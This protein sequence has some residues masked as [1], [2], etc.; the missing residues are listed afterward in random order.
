MRTSDHQPTYSHLGTLS[1]GP[2]RIEMHLLT[3]KLPSI[4]LA[5]L[6]TAV[7][8]QKR[9]LSSEDISFL[10]L[11]QHLGYIES[12][13]FSTTCDTFS[14]NDPSAT[15]FPAGLQAALCLIAEQK[16]N[17]VG[18]IG[19]TLQSNGAESIPPCTYVAPSTD[20]IDVVYTALGLTYIGLGAYIG[21]S[22][23]SS[24]PCLCI[25]IKLTHVPAF[26]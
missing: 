19:S 5:S 2:I 15:G 24:L 11:V 10:H 4:L 3:M 6:A 21:G 26:E 14:D 18:A 8:L 1:S 22:G 17:E 20:P 9:A 7:P 12:H 23:V 13:F 16:A 25:Q